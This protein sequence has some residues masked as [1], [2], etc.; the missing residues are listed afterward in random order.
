[1]STLLQRACEEAHSGNKDNANKVR[2]IG[3][4]FLNAVQVSAQEAVFLILQM[5]LRK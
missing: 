5:P 2:Y 3:N 1:M 4:K